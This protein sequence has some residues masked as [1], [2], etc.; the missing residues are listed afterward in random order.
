MVSMGPSEN[1]SK[2][3]FRAS[4]AIIIGSI[5]GAGLFMKP[6]SMAA[7]LGSPVAMSLVWV[8]AGFFTLCGALVYAELGAMMP[9]TGGLFVHFRNIFGN[10]TAFLYGW[11]AFAVI[12]TASVAAIAF[13]CASYL[14]KVISLPVVSEDLVSYYAI[15][16]PFLGKLYPLRDI[17]IK[18]VAVLLVCL[19]TWLNT[20]SL[21]AGSWFQQL[22]SGLNISI[23]LFLVIGIFISGNGSS[24]NFYQ[25]QAAPMTG[26]FLTGWVAAMTGA[27]FAYDGW[28]NI[29]SMAGEVKDPQRNIPRSLWTGV[30]VCIAIYL[31]VNQAYLYVLPVSKMAGSVLV[32]SDAI[33]QAWGYSASLLV[34]C[35]IIAVTIGC[36]NGNIMATSRIT[37]AMGKEGVFAPWTGK[38]HARFKTPSHALWLHGTWTSV[39]I[40]TG[41]FD[42]LADMFVFITWIAYT[43]GAIGII[44]WRIKYPEKY[45]PYKI[46]GHPV[47][48]LAFIS[49]SLFYLG[50]TVYKDVQMYQR[51][52]QP[53]INSLLGLCITILG[54]PLYY[55]FRKKNAS[56]S[57]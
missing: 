12:N 40:L 54:L 13:V 36:I 34:A 51:G 15:P 16:L 28:V 37:Y 7:Q 11:S 46:W 43:L 18:L 9:H 24:S 57:I 44:Y 41:S 17:G 5:I 35:M 33:E 55:Y 6:A 14:G 25:S 32:A 53:V 50:A 21:K 38:I 19:L 42:L 4:L 2:L 27:F 29:V 56:P 47:T 52:L 31:L 48:T 45:R 30:L 22:T 10:K 20:R 1:S 49:F 23:L 26:S 3:T 8:V 39:L